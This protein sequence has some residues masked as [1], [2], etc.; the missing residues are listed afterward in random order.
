MKA[1]SFLQG[2]FA[3]APASIEPAALVAQLDQG[4]PPAIL[5]VRGTDEFHGALGRIPGAHNVPLPDLA[6]A[7]PGL[8][9]LKHSRVVVVCRTDRRSAA[10]AALLGA[11]GWRAEVLRGGMELWN[12]LGYPVSRAGG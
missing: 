9:A 6:R 3:A 12:R 7:L 10:A 4:E 2:L 1:A 8:E 11:A 5:D